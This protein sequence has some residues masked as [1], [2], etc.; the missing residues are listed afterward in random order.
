[1]TTSRATSGRGAAAQALGQ[2]AVFGVDR[3]DLA[4]RGRLRH[5][6]T[7]GDQRFLVGQRQHP[8]GPQRGKGRLEADRPGDP[9]EHDVGVDRLDEF[10]GGPRTGDLRPAAHR[11]GQAA[12]GDRGVGMRERPAPRAT[13]GAPPPAASPT[14]SNISGCAAMTSS[15]WVPIE[16]VEPSMM[17]RRRPGVPGP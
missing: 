1:M 14:T 10:G 16:P 8:A 7:T 9:V 12:D 6:R 15:A 5:Q 11:P 4:G 3:H 13:R 2:R 17:T